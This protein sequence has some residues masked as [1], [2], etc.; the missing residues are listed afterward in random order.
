MLVTFL[1]LVSLPITLQKKRQDRA[2]LCLSSMDRQRKVG[3]DS[4]EKSLEADLIPFIVRW[5]FL[6]IVLTRT[7]DVT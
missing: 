6:Y 1:F 5:R 7:L 3:D 4:K 2:R